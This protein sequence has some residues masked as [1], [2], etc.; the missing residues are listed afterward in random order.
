MISFDNAIDIARAPDDVYAYLADLEHTPEWNWAITRTEKV[1]PGPAGIGTRYRQTRSV[2]RP[3]VEFIEISDL[4]P[5]RSI[6]V[7]GLL[8]PFRA[9]L[10]YEVAATPVGTRLTNRV[11]LST[12]LPLGPLG[13]VLGSRVKASVAENLNVLRELLE[14]PLN[15]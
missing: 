2:P 10:S 4:H 8:G 11:Q 9:R 5:G 3:A 14:R 1:T 15:P 7:A 13:D 6:D 12:P